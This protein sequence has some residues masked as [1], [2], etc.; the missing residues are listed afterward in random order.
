MITSPNG[1]LLE[2]RALLD[3]A[4]SVSFVSERLAQTLRLPRTSQNITVSGIAGL[5]HRT[6]IQFVTSFKVSPISTGRETEI[7]AIIIP[8]V[9]LYSR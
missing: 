5:Q 2:A 1:F 9:T 4:S 3:N 8:K 7:T 6:P